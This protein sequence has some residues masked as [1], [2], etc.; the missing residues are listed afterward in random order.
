MEQPPQYGIDIEPDG[1]T[2]VARNILIDNCHIH[3]NAVGSIV[4]ANVSNEI[5]GVNITNCILD[6]VNA[7]GGQNVSIHAC[8]IGTVFLYNDSEATKVTDCAMDRIYVEDNG[9]GIF[10]NCDVSG[11][12]FAYLILIASSTAIRL[13]F[14]NC[15]FSGGSNVVNLISEQASSANL[16]ELVEFV[17]C[18]ITLTAATALLASYLRIDKLR[19][20]GC[21]IV[22]TGSK[23]RVFQVGSGATVQIE[24]KD[25]AI[26][27]ATAPTYIF[28][29]A[30]NSVCN[31]D[32]AGST[33]PNSTYFIYG[34]GGASGAITLFHNKMANVTVRGQGS[35]TVSNLNTP[36]TTDTLPKYDGSVA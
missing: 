6:N 29:N 33:L 22:H 30:A 19:L 35:F 4:I 24:V 28:A 11:G 14:H 7:Q 36:L 34:D 20:I 16:S 9:R 18:S 1:S 21:T 23:D 15:R 26:R 32:I 17:D 25:T 13:Q 31:A 2:G 5:S 8:T 27:Y 10:S 3:D 12:Q